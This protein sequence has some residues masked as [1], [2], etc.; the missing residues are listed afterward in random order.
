MADMVSDCSWPREA[1]EYMCD[2][3]SGWLWATPM[4]RGDMKSRLER[5]VRNSCFFCIG[6]PRC[7]TPSRGLYRRLPHLIL[8]CRCPAWQRASTVIRPML[9]HTETR[10]FLSLQVIFSC[11]HYA[12]TCETKQD[13]LTNH[14]ADVTGCQQAASRLEALFDRNGES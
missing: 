8:S 7:S 5:Q 6:L 10:R 14:G 2:G 9:L 12:N 11:C 3:C 4:Q 13:E 1:P